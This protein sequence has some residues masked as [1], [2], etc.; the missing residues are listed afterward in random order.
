MCSNGAM[1]FF[2]YD[3]LV[4]ICM[5]CALCFS[6]CARAPSQELYR[7][8]ASCRVG[9][10]LFQPS[11]QNL[12]AAEVSQLIV[13]FMAEHWH[14]DEL[15]TEDR[16]AELTRMCADRIQSLETLE[17][18]VPQRLVEIEYRGLYLKET[19]HSWQQEIVLRFRARVRANGVDSDDLEKVFGETA[20]VATDYTPTSTIKVSEDLL[21]P[22]KECRQRLREMLSDAGAETADTI[23]QVLKTSASK[24]AIID[25]HYMIDVALL[26]M[27][28]EPG[29]R[30]RLME[31][32]LKAAPTKLAPATPATVKQRLEQLQLS[33]LYK[34]SARA[35]QQKIRIAA[36]ILGAISEGRRPEN[37]DA[38]L[39]D[40]S[41]SPFVRSLVNFFSFQ[42]V[43]GAKKE[44]C[45]HRGEVAIPFIIADAEA[46]LKAKTATL[47]TVAQL[48]TMDFLVPDAHRDAAIAITKAIDEQSGSKVKTLK[49]KTDASASSSGAAPSKK[50][51]KR[52]DGHAAAMAL[53]S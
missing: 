52:D 4:I 7:L 20:L 45:F 25:E 38:A 15:V 3:V 31:V 39:K 50:R 17:H 11:C 21:V 18:L 19:V 49:S 8:V 40:S 35:D 26:N 36:A 34:L 1:C 14:T 22:A 46:Q 5:L 53:F 43:R 27:L 23:Q 48:S 51:L 16:L 44:K 13:D 30:S 28:T 12:L 42:E 2:V 47:A 32:M 33:E 41:L 9:E 10:L 24:L 6:G 37:V 29:Q